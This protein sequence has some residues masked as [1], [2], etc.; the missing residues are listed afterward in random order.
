MGGDEKWRH[1]LI[2]SS[3]VAG[4]RVLHKD[5][6]FKIRKATVRKVI[7]GS[8]ALFYKGGDK[9]YTRKLNFSLGLTRKGRNSVCTP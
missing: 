2:N 5:Q 1:S 6:V 8:I 3:G 4:V 7:T 9:H